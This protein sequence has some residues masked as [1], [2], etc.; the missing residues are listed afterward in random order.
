VKF[1]KKYAFIGVLERGDDG[2][3]VTAEKNVLKLFFHK[4][5]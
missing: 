4:E 5:N 2:N 1:I 3:K